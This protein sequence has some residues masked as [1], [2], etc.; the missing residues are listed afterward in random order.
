MKIDKERGNGERVVLEALR[1]TDCF[2]K[3][4]ETRRCWEEPVKAADPTH[5]GSYERLRLLWVVFA[6][7]IPA[8][9]LA[10]SI[11]FAMGILST[12]ILTVILAIVITL[13]N[14][15]YS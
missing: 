4:Q 11:V 15:V 12:G 7:L 10:I 3:E 2:I 5:D 8:S 14:S 13:V 6:V 9:A 1:E